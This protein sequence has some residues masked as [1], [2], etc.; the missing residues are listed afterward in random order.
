MQSEKK[1]RKESQRLAA[2][3]E[4]AQSGGFTG[5]RQLTLQDSTECVNQWDIYD[6]RALLFTK[7]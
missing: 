5:L 3:R 7:G 2:R 4:K 1:T 6:P